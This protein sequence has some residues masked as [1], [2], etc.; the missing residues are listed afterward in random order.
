M[1][2]RVRPGLAHSG[3]A[4]RGPVADGREGPALVA[5]PVGPVP[6]RELESSGS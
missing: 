5:G 1:R 2:C 4:V 3:V 6:G